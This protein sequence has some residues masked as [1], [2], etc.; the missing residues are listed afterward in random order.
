MCAN[1]YGA[2]GK[3]LTSAG[4]LPRVIEEAFKQRGPAIIG[5]PIDY[6]ENMKM[7]KRLGQIEFPI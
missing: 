4:E 5:V 2:W 6:S 1:S 3:T 7:S